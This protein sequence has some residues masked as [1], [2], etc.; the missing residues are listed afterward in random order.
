MEYTDGSK[1]SL[2]LEDLPSRSTAVN[3]MLGAIGAALQLAAQESTRAAPEREVAIYEALTAAVPQIVATAMDMGAV[4][5]A[6]GAAI[7]RDY[8]TLLR[9]THDPLA[10]AALRAGQQFKGVG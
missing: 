6:I 10:G 3:M 5:C 9:N 8:E 4:V 1:A 7:P 2:V